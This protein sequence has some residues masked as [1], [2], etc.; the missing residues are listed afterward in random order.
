MGIQKNLR[1]GTLGVG[2]MYLITA[3]HRDVSLVDI[4]THAAI[5]AINMNGLSGAL[6]KNVFHR[7][8]KLGP[9]DSR[10]SAVGR[11]LIPAS[12]PLCRKQP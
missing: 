5:V 10:S 3:Q 7:L 9:I 1:G 8:V 12:M 4:V 11:S 6:A 2:P